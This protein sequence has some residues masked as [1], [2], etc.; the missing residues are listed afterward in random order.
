MPT[1]HQVFPADTRRAAT[2]GTLAV[3]ALTSLAIAPCAHAQDLYLTTGTYDIL[4]PY[5]GN[6]YA[7]K[8]TSGSLVDSGGNPYVATSLVDFETTVGNLNSYNTSVTTVNGG[9]AD[10]TYGYNSSVTNIENGYSGQPDVNSVFALDTST[11]NVHSAY[12]TNATSRINGTINIDGASYVSSVV[13]YNN[14]TVNIVDMA[15]P[16]FNYG[17]VDRIDAHDNSTINLLGGNGGPGTLLGLSSYAVTEFYGLDSSTINVSGGSVSQTGIN[18]SNNSVTN[19]SGGIVPYYRGYDLG[20]SLSISGGAVTYAQTYS[21][22]PVNVSGG[23]VNQIVVQGG[24][25]NGGLAT[26]SLNMT[27]GTV[28][29]AQCDREPINL[30]GGTLGVALVVTRGVFD[31]TGGTLTGAVSMFDSSGTAN[32]VGTGL[33]IVYDDSG[34][35]GYHELGSFYILGGY[36]FTVTGTIG[37]IAGSSI[38]VILPDS[39]TS[40]ANSTP[41]QITFNGVAATLSPEPGAGLLVALAA[42][43]L[44]LFGRLL[45]RL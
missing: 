2:V 10:S 16:A 5:Y 24:V 41:R 28:G 31:M 36:R 17:T 35:Y 22:S 33:S 1:V 30:S 39:G 37:G 8:D 40:S 13:T 18:S 44:C 32:F 26:G 20:T 34:Q 12:V 38:D 3:L 25:V 6:V 9:Y 45:R 42:P 43:G 29:A 4:S 11:T 23:V 27:G 14:S 7:G 15:D 19:I 21:A